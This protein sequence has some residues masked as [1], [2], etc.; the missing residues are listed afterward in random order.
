MAEVPAPAPAP[1]PEQPAPEVQRYNPPR[2]DPL[3]RDAVL[4]WNIQEIMRYNLFSAKVNLVVGA[5]NPSGASGSATR[6]QVSITA[7][8]L[9]VEGL[10]F[11]DVNLNVDGATTG[12]NGLDTGALAVSTWYAVWVIASTRGESLAGLLSAS[13]TSPTLPAGY[14]LKRKVGAVRTG[15]S[16]AEFWRFFHFGNWWIWNEDI[17]NTTLPFLLIGSRATTPTTIT[18]LAPPGSRMIEVV[19]QA[20]NSALGVRFRPTGSNW[21]NTGGAGAVYHN[22]TVDILGTARMMLNASQ[23]VDVWCLQSPGVNDVFIVMERGF[24]FEV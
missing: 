19:V 16:V 5:T 2:H 10:G 21:A 17:G 18:A 24:H 4:P 23:Q 22:T 11:K 15:G 9:S 13:F 20:Y 12:A 3:F 1:A 8:Y 7:D 6:K 14:T